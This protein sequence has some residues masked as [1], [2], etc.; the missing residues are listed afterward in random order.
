MPFGIEPD[1]ARHRHQQLLATALGPVE[2]GDDCVG[3]R[4]LPMGPPPTAEAIGEVVTYTT[5]VALD[6]MQPELT[7]DERCFAV[8]VAMTLSDPRGWTRSGVSFRRVSNASE[9]QLV[10]TLAS[11]ATVDQE[12]APLRTN[13]RF[14]CWNG[15]RAMLN[16]ER[17][18]TGVAGFEDDLVTYRTYMI[19]H[20]VGH[21]LGH[22]HRRCPLADAL[23]PVMMQQSKTTGACRPN[24]W[25]T[26]TE[27]G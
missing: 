8:V 15:R 19:N 1:Q 22:G 12:C 10:V 7:V 2:L 9:A 13:G 4:I 6:E 21:G 24:G 18:L 3:D 14:S 5:E 11:P 16:V 26:D 20:E 23:A 27:V 25:P 17:W